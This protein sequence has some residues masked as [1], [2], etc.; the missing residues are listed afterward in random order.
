MPEH[1]SPTDQPADSTLVHVKSSERWRKRIRM[2]EIVRVL[3]TQLLVNDLQHYFTRKNLQKSQAEDAHQD[4]LLGSL[5][6]QLRNDWER[7]HEYHD[8]GNNVA[9]SVDVPLREVGDAGGRDAG[10]PEPL[11][12]RADEDLDEDLRCAPTAD[13][14]HAGNAYLSHS[15]GENTVVLDEERHLQAHEG[16]IVEDDRDV[17]CLHPRVNAHFAVAAAQ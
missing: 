10:V 4:P 5:Q 17:E 6:V 11:D 1:S 9:G 13:D 8:V 12:G 15:H 14:D 2:K 16:R 7:E 3:E